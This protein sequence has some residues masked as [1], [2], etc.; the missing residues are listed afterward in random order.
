MLLGCSAVAALPL[1][2]WLSHLPGVSFP[3][4]SPERPLVS[5]ARGYSFYLSPREVGFVYKDVSLPG[6]L[7]EKGFSRISFD[8]SARFRSFS[9]PPRGSSF[10]PAASLD[11]FFP[12]TRSDPPPLHALRTPLAF[13]VG[14][15]L[16]PPSSPIAGPRKSSF[17]STRLR[18]VFLLLESLLPRFKDLSPPSSCVWT[19]SFAEESR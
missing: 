17:L 10:F 18:R 6:R 15:N 3:L 19:L 13:V 8:L 1:P 4:L 7:G 5:R 14:W 2:F 12:R 16:F 11:L 9:S